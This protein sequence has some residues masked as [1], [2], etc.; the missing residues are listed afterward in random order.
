MRK[1]A[2]HPWL[3]GTDWIGGAAAERGQ[4]SVSV[5][6]FPIPCFSSA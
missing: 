4:E 6:A 5:S 2:G 3:S 1:R